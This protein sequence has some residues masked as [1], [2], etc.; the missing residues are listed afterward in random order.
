MGGQLT[1]LAGIGV[2]IAASLCVGTAG[3]KLTGP[4]YRSGIASACMPCADRATWTGI[5]RGEDDRIFSQAFTFGCQP[6]ELREREFWLRAGRASRRDVVGLRKSA[7]LDF[8]PA[9]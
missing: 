3:V 2:D 6:P 5:F 7:N 1:Q 8:F 9:L 4:S